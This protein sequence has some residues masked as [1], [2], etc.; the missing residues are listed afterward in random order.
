MAKAYKAI[1]GVKRVNFYFINQEVI[2]MI[3]AEGI[4][5]TR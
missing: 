3:V 2:E 1:M 5:I 4:G